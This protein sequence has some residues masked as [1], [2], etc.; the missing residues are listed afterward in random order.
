M[1]SSLRGAAVAGALATA[2]PGLPAAVIAAAPQAASAAASQ[3]DARLTAW[4]DREYDHYLDLAPME[5]SSAGD[6]SRDYD[7][8]DDLSEAGMAA[9]VAFRARS[10]A[11]MK[12]MF[13]RTKLAADGKLS[14]DLWAYQAQEAANTYKFRRNDYL[15]NQY[16]GPQ[17]MLVRFLIQVHNVDQPSDMTAYI[18]RIRG[19]ARAIGQDLERAKTNAAGGVRAPR[20]AYDGVIEQA[21][22]LASGAPFDTPSKT[23]APNSVWADA[24]AKID[25]LQK[26]GKI[27]GLQADAFKAEARK[28]LIEA[29]GPTYTRLAAWLEADRP[30]SVANATGVGHD[31]NGQAYY[32]MA[33]ANQTTTDLTPD[34]VHQI[35]LRKVVEI[36]AQMEAIKDKVGFKGSLQDFFT[37]LRTDDRFYFPDTDAGRQGY[38]DLATQ[39]ITDIRKKLPDYFG[40][41]PKAGVV[42]KRVEAYREQPGGAQHYLFPA[43]DG[44]RP[45]TF[46]A[47]LSDMRAMPKWQLEAIAYHEAGLGHHMQFAIMQELHGLPKFRMRLFY[48]AFQEGWGLYTEQQLGKEMGG[49]TDPYSDF[50]RLSTAIWRAVRLVVDTGVHA[51]GWTEAQAVQYFLENSPQAEGAVRAEVRRYM[52]WPGQATGYMIGYLRIM[53]LRHK[54]EREL[55]PKFDIRGFHDLLLGHGQMPLNLLERQVD[56]WIAAKKAG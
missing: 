47:H 24:L 3:S 11:Q 23:G 25:K 17:T 32:A 8:I 22:G 51:K 33:L 43:P 37:F 29:W 9:R 14:Y 46:Y 54:A 35:G 52:T 56:D 36:K 12:A 39:Y 15:F 42:V 5:R 4:L 26:A 20:F 10:V 30:N 48:N 55:G 44:S 19:L 45:G 6:K 16:F 1:I 38:I 7:K 18:A 31:P 41:V 40:M 2:M 27:D 34:Q 53:E 28:A 13:D 21:H 50:G 49:F